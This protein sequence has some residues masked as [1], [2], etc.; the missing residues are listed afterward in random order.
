MNVGKALRISLAEKEMTQ[1]DLAVSLGIT[2][3]T[4]SGWIKTNSMPLR[5]LEV[6]ASFFG[7][8]PSEFLALG[9]A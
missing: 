1:G 3:Q 8:S 5:T 9:E 6:V 4:V 2:P 7:K